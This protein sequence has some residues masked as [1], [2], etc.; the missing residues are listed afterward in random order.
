[1]HTQAAGGQKA[2]LPLHNDG[3]KASV[4]F[5]AHQV[6]AEK[7]KQTG[8]TWQNF[9]GEKKKPC[10]LLWLRGRVCAP[11]ISRWVRCVIDATRGM[12]RQLLARASAVLEAD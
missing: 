12:M 9:G 4:P 10:V 7:Q 1:M 5:G 3:V 8:L 2:R 11:L 6:A